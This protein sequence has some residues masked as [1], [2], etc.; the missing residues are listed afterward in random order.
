M[1]TPEKI[2]Y[3]RSKLG[4]SQEAFSKMSG[5]SLSSIKK[6]ESGRA[7]PK[8]QQLKRIADALCVSLNLFTDYDIDT[9]S[10]VMALITKMDESVDIVIDAEYDDSQKPIPGTIKISF[11]HPA[12]NEQLA[13]LLQIK[14]QFNGLNSDK[15]KYLDSPATM[16]KIDELNTILEQMRLDICNSPRVVKKGVNG[17]AVKTFPAN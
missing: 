10:D 17:I 5:I 6:I 13:L 7:N 2:K 11:S 16:Q 12:I 3:Y 14:K 4:L 15:E 8:P 9:V 1:T